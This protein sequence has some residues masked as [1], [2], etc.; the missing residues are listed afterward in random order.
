[1]SYGCMGLHITGNLTAQRFT[2]VTFFAF[3]F[4]IYV[5][6]FSLSLSLS[7]CANM[8]LHFDQCMY[9][10]LGCFLSRSHYACICIYSYTYM[11]TYIH[12]YIHTYTYIHTYVYIYI[13][14]L[15]VQFIGN[16]WYSNN[17]RS[18]SQTGSMYLIDIHI[19]THHTYTYIMYVCTQIHMDKPSPLRSLVEKIRYVLNEVGR[20]LL[21]RQ[22]KD[23]YDFIFKQTTPPGKLNG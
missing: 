9:V 22:Y 18:G 19:H 21:A 23:F 11:H 17:S 6:F 14:A 20:V 16:I 12:I 5:L 7:L 2:T 1:M 15:A 3:L 13:Q 4:C 8:I 10:C